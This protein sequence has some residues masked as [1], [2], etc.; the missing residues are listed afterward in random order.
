M[1]ER[2]IRLTQQVQAAIRGMHP[3]LKRR[4]R[5]AL[6][7]IRASPDS[8]K[9]LLGELAGWWSVRVGRIRIVYR[10]RSRSS[11]VEVAA[12]GPRA[13]IYSE[14]VRLVRAKGDGV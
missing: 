1:P 2:A 11:P 6:D 14:A 10:H 12:I 5:A 8:G 3:V 13:S 4:V 9:P 7:H